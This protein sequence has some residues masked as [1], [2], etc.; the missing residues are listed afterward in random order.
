MKNIIGVILAVL[1]SVVAMGAECN[2][3]L[4]GRPAQT[5]ASSQ[6]DADKLIEELLTVSGMKRSLERLPEQMING[7]RQSTLKDGVAPDIR[8][9]VLRIMMD[10]YPREGFINRVRDAL[11]KNYSQQRY[12]HLLQLL[13]TPLVKRMTDLEAIDPSPGDIQKFLSQI[14]T[15]PLSPHRVRLI[16]TMDTVTQSSSLLTKMTI[17][18]LEPNALATADDC[19]GNVSAIKKAIAKSRPQIEK[20]NRRATEVVFAYTYRN[21]SDSDLNE[22]L[23][24]YEDQ[25]GKWIQGLI[26]AAVGQEFKSDSETEAQGLRQIV[27]AHEPKQTMF[28]PKCD[29][30]KSPQG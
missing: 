14:S 16:Q 29:E 1:S 18:F 19:N 17:A 12:A 22:Y 23:K 11:K 4:A 6:N 7:V 25:D 27:Q 20:A 30:R 8:N 28:A 10:A 15:Q 24:T 5:S 13:S 21:V 2:S 26:Q 3:T 9:D